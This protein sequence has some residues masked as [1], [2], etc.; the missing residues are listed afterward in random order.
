MTPHDLLPFGIYETPITARIHERI[1]ETQ[2]AIPTAASGITEATTKDVD[3]RFAA[4][5]SQHFARVIEQRL[6]EIK[7]PEERVALINNLAQHLGADEK[8]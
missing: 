1:K 7:K 4:A 5:V 3:P 8:V 2:R 6:L